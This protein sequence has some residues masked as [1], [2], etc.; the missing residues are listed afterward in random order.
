MN[1][2]RVDFINVVNFCGAI[3][4]ASSLSV[5][6][7]RPGM[8]PIEALQLAI[9][10]FHN[11]PKTEA[12][13]VHWIRACV[14]LHH[15]RHPREPGA[16]EVAARLDS[17]APDWSSSASCRNQ[18]PCA[19]VLHNRRVLET[20][21]PELEG[22]YR[23]G[24]PDRLLEVVSASERMAVLTR[25]IPPFGLRG[26][27]RCGAGLR[28]QGGSSLRVE[29][30]SAK[31][32]AS[33]GWRG[34][35]DHERSLRPDR[36]R[37]QLVLALRPASPPPNRSPGDL[38]RDCAAAWSE[39]LIERR[40]CGRSEAGSQ[41]IASSGMWERKCSKAAPAEGKSWTAAK[42]PLE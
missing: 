30:E 6:G 11:S 22:L 9:R 21:V 8:T 28:V 38:D 35:I 14:H 37:G 19:L 16:P 23:V 34:A 40:C 29:G 1:L 26:Q 2:A 25:L 12:A 24:R 42:G 20:E 18:A 31:G 36:A 27:R 17:R 13:C 5:S 39:V 33:R 10:K 4:S 41:R 15:R 7:E 3:R 32:A